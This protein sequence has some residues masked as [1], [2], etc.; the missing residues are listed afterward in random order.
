[1]ADSANFSG[2]SAH[3]D[4]AVDCNTSIDI[5]DLGRASCATSAKDEVD[6]DQIVAP[7]MEDEIEVAPNTFAYGFEDRFAEVDDNNPYYD[8]AIKADDMN[9]ITDPNEIV[10]PRS[11]KDASDEKLGI[12][13]DYVQFIL[14]RLEEM[15]DELYGEVTNKKNLKIYEA[16]RKAA[17][18]EFHISPKKTE[19]YY[20]Y[21]VICNEMG[22]KPDSA[23]VGMMQTKPFRSESGVIVFAVFTHPMWREAGTGKMKAFSCMYDCSYCPQQPGRPRSYVDGEPGNDRAV[24]VNYD[25]TKQVWIRGN[26]YR[27]NGHP[28]DKAEV[29]ILGGTFHSYQDDYHIEFFRNLYYAFNTINGERERPMLTLEEEMRL[30]TCMD[31]E[32]LDQYAP[33]HD[34]CRV[35]GLTIETRPDQIKDKTLVKL[36]EYGVTR[37]QLGVQH[38]DNRVL[39]RVNRGC[40][41]EDAIEAILNLKRCGFKVDIH[42]MPDLPK[43]YTE[44]FVREAGYRLKSNKMVIKHEDIDWDFDMVESDRQ[45]FEEVFHGEDYC[46][47]Q[48]KIYPFQVMDWTKL[49]DEHARGLHVS[50]AEFDEG[51]DPAQNE[52]MKTLVDAK[53][54]IPRYVRINRLKRDIPDSYSLGGLTDSHGRDFIHRLMDQLGLKCGCIRCNEIKKKAINI[55][56]VYLKVC[57]YRASQA[58]EYFIF[59]TDDEDHV[60]GFVRL[61]LDPK[62]G[63][64]SKFRRGTT[65]VR[66]EK[67]VFPEL[68]RS[69]MIRELHVYGEAVKVSSNTANARSQQHVGFG[70]RLVYASFLIA[71]AEGY[72][73]MSVIPGEG[74]KQ[75]YHKKFGFVEEGHYMTLDIS[76]LLVMGDD[77]FSGITEMYEDPAIVPF[78]PQAD[79]D[80]DGDSEYEYDS[81]SEDD[82]YYMMEKIK[83][84]IL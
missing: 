44:E 70:T 67:Q 22:V 36:R 39:L 11:L 66:S 18:K 57:K 1:M 13:N 72:R 43:P 49:K 81:D 38:T 84:T 25:T 24:S 29:I 35:I 62:A 28:I 61:R 31:L 27:A 10:V 42:L 77:G 9:F 17:C 33:D 65:E 59:Y 53:S 7:E 16:V 76:A 79:G 37:V 30:N 19:I 56:E 2:I 6:V 51:E 55:D 60:I 47:D 45:M 68:Y 15:S 64:V 50:Y 14:E 58:D 34:I 52:L 75:Y 82:M 4:V 23:K 80:S 73:K 40:L 12:L 54:R 26:T 74:V 3:N 21:K 46:P 32:L 41:A 83:C 8:K 78:Y 20:M 71:Y 48:V 5:E 63:F 69:A